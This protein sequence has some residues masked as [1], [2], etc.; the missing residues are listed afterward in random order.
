M[1]VAKRQCCGQPQ[2]HMMTLHDLSSESSVCSE[3]RILFFFI[4]SPSLVNIKDAGLIA[5]RLFIRALVL[6]LSWV[7]Y[8]THAK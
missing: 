4:R 1:E 8:Y 7:S 6:K 3:A 2:R 5:S